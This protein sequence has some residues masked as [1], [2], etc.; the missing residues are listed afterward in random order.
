MTGPPHAGGLAGRTSW[1]QAQGFNF[2]GP[3]GRPA[4]AKIRQ[5]LV[6]LPRHVGKPFAHAR[7]SVRIDNFRLQH[8]SR[9]IG[10]EIFKGAGGAA[11]H[12]PGR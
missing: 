11:K 10:G 7:S 4:A 9:E 2:P 3:G 6:P 12:G 8:G 1:H 5:P